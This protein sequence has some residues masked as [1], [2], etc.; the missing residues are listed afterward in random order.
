MLLSNQWHFVESFDPKKTLE[1]GFVLI[2]QN[3]KWLKNSAAIT[4]E[5]PLKINFQDGA[6]NAKIISDQQ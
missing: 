3:N 2:E 1:R 5:D 6:I 4:S